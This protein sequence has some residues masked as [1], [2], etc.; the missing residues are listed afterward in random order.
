MEVQAEE[1]G[2]SECLV[3]MTRIG[4]ESTDNIIPHKSE[5]TSIWSFNA[6]S[7]RELLEMEEA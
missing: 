4:V 5:Q 3:V 6:R 2:K 1:D 7:R